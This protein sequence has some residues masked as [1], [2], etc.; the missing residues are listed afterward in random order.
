MGGAG[1]RGHVI[2]ATVLAVSDREHGEPR[3]AD[4][5]RRIDT[6]V[7]SPARMYDY[8]LGGKDNF[9]AD[10]KAADKVL[11]A[12]PELRRMAWQNRRFLVR[13]AGFLARSGVRQFLDLGTGIPTSPNV[14]EVVRAIHPDAPI[15]YVDND[16]IVSAYNRALRARRPG[17]IA[18]EADI[19][20]PDTILNDPAVRDA[21]DFS[22]PIA[23]LALAV[24]HFVPGAAPVIATFLDAVPSGSY[25]AISAATSDGLTEDEMRI[26]QEIYAAASVTLALRTRERFEALFTGADLL[27]PGVVPAGRWD[28]DESPTHPTILAGVARVP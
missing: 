14:H 17:I 4:R 22:R 5:P 15:V 20:E 16:P 26:G 12:Y 2:T 23:V 13:A 1:P 24:L 21:L 10:R 6:T 7:P 19:R 25:L 8:A 18:I 11:A 27:P 3:A 28:A 9:A